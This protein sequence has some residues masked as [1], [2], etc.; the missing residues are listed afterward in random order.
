VQIYYA[1]DEWTA[2]APQSQRTYRHILEHFR[3]EHGER[4]VALLERDHVKA[5]VSAK[6][7]TPAAANKF[8]KL[9]SVLMQV[10]VDK[11]WRKDNPVAGVKGIRIKSEGFKTWSEDHIAQY[12]VKHEVDT[13]ARLALALLLYTGQRRGDVIRMGRQHIRDGVL[14]IRQ[15]KT[16]MEVAIPIHPK[17]QECLAAA[18]RNHLT[19]LVTEYG[20]PF[21]PAGFTNWFRD[22]CAFAGLPTGLSPHGLRKA[23]C[24]RL[25]EAGCTPHAIMAIS[26]HKSLAEVTRYT[27]AASRLR[28]ARDAMRTITVAER[29]TRNGK[30]DA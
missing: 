26:G 12:E 21:T 1:S 15:Q 20:Q 23:M 5:M 13:K 19:F 18:P 3:E 24:R 11:G 16:G 30:P 4:P 17:L 28:L 22:R 2:L 25:A 8:R 29:R 9:L 10:A 7:A 14:T 27:E 6:A